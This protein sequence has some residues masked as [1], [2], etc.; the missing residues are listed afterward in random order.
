MIEEFNKNA[1]AATQKYSELDKVV[2]GEVAAIEYTYDG[3]PYVSVGR[4]SIIAAL[5]RHCDGPPM[6]YRPYV[7]LRYY[8]SCQ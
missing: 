6:P 7:H 8:R 3:K 4:G 2:E 1:V 5:R